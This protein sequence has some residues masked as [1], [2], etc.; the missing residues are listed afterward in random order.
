LKSN[1]KSTSFKLAN[2]TVKTTEFILNQD[3]VQ[4]QELNLSFTPLKIEKLQFEVNKTTTTNWSLSI[5]SKSISKGIN[6]PVQIE[7]F[8]KN[9]LKSVKTRENTKSVN[10]FNKIGKAVVVGTNYRR[11]LPLFKNRFKGR[12]KQSKNPRLVN[13]LELV[14][15]SLYPKSEFNYNILLDF[16]DNKSL[17]PFQREGVTFLLE[18]DKALL[19]D[20]MGLGKSIQAIVATRLLFR[21]GVVK[22]CL[23]VCPKSVLVDWENKLEE[24]AKE[25]EISTI[26]GKNSMRK[27]QWSKNVSIYLV[28]YDTLR[29]DVLITTGKKMNNSTFDLVILDEIQRIK[30]SSTKTYQTIK[31]INAKLCWGLSGTPLENRIEELTTIFSYLKPELF[32][33]IEVCDQTLVK[34]MIEPFMLRRTK[35]NVLRSLPEKIENRV[36]LDLEPKQRITYNAIEKEGIHHIKEKGEKANI[37]HILALISKLKQICNIEP[38]SGES[39]KLEYLEDKLTNLT[40]TGDKMIVF[41]QYPEKTL[42]IIEPKLRRF[43]PV[44]YHGSL[45]STQREA[46]LK[47]FDEDE[48]IKVILISLKA[49]GLGNEHSSKKW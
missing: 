43:N 12:R 30:N 32:H 24:W 48:S 38:I 23:I 35:S 14:L 8:E 45:S 11:S 39:C 4:V 20:E 47:Q 33:K 10:A 26:S 31:Q 42:K 28:T 9:F 22:K 19:A 29:E 49:G 44:I 40:E 13:V 27:K 41:S 16:P 46:I 5:P 7:S 34:E 1:K 18:Q 3:K 6:G 36:Y 37:T 25:L 15:P 2:L 21:F 17:F